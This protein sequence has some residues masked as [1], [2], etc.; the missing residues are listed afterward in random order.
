MTR[1]AVVVLGGICW[2]GAIAFGAAHLLAG[3]LVAPAVMAAAF[4]VWLT[5]RLGVLA[6]V[7][8]ES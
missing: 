5:L 6:K 3:D 2:I 4:G 7:P 8:V 1:N